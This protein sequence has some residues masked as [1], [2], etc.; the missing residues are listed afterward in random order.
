MI[1]KNGEI[2]SEG[3]AHTTSEADSTLDEL[4]SHAEESAL[5]L[6]LNANVDVSEAD[7]YVMGRRESG[8]VRITDKSYCCV[9]C[10]RL[11]VQTRIENVVY[12]TVEGWNKIS[13]QEMF[14]KALQRVPANTAV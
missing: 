9:R 12:P 10:S 14:N 4:L 3:Y 5:L 7:I 13:V 6:A 8:E 11:L 1:V 2:L